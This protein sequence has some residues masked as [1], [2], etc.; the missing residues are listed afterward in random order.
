MAALWG[1][2]PWPTA[3]TRT[4]TGARRRCR[5]LQAGFMFCFRLGMRRGRA[6]YGRLK[7]SN[8]DLQPITNN[9]GID[10]SSNNRDDL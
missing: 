5:P 4:G 10:C 6:S 2:E 3:Y 7:L 9:A 1:N 8:R